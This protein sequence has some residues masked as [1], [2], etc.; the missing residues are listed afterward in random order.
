MKRSSVILLIAGLTSTLALSGQSVP[1][2]P[3]PHELATG[4][5]QIPSTPSERAAALSLLERARQNAEMHVPGGSPF[6]IRISF[7][8]TGAGNTFSGPGSM[9][10]LWFSGRQWR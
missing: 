3:D 8:A 6:N 2:P 5:V 10:E 4:P 1:V 7:N 9:T